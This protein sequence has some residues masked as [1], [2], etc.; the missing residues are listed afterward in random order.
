LRFHKYVGLILTFSN[1]WHWTIHDVADRFASLSMIVNAIL[2]NLS[3]TGLS[4][5]WGGGGAVAHSHGLP[6]FGSAFM[7]TF[8]NQ[9]GGAYYVPRIFGPSYGPTRWPTLAMDEI[10]IEVDH[11]GVKYFLELYFTFY[12][13]SRDIFSNITHSFDCMFFSSILSQWSFNPL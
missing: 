10:W 5:S 2:C 13:L 8:S 3:K 12:V 6:D 4:E 9:G 7:Q 1:N 11:N